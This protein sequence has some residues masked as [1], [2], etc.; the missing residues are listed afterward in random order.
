MEARFK[1]DAISFKR[2]I[3]AVKEVVTEVV[4]DCS[5]DGIHMQAMDN[6]HIAL[7]FFSLFKDEA[8]SFYKCNKET[9]IGI[10]ILALQ[11]VL[12]LCNNDDILT[13][14][15]Q[16]NEDKL[17][18][19]FES[20]NG[21]KM[22]QFC[23]S[24][25]NIDQESLMI[26]DMEYKTYFT[27]SSQELVRICKDFKE[28]NDTI[29]ISSQ[30]NGI[31]FSFKNETS[32][33]KVTLV[34]NTSMDDD[35]LPSTIIKVKEPTTATFSSKYLLFFTKGC[36]LSSIVNISLSNDLPLTIEYKFTEGNLRYYMAPKIVEE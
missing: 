7:V 26:P 6:S 5:S 18:L 30:K 31:T 34:P 9:S 21:S 23:I 35:T 11:K 29:D 27:M 15:K 2:I 1:N 28:L 8:F 36:P 4:F 32:E 22:S 13:L 17:D 25:L 19:L 24:L 14:Q 3:D 12:K 33:G 10:N 20:P 16:E